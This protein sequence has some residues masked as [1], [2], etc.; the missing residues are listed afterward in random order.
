MTSRERRAGSGSG[1]LL[2]LDSLWHDAQGKV[3]D[4]RTL[5]AALEHPSESTTVAY[6]ALG[7]VLAAQVRNRTLQT[8][9]WKLEEF[10]PDA[11][12]NVWF[13]RSR[14]AADQT[15]VGSQAS[16]SGNGALTSQRAAPPTTCPGNPYYRDSLY[17]AVDLGGSV[18][19][20]GTLQRA[21]DATYTLQTASASYYAADGRLHV[22][23]RYQA[24]PGVGLGSWEEYWYDALGRRVL[25]RARRDAAQVC[26]IGV[27]CASF[28]QRTVW[29]GDQVLFEQRTS[30]LDAITG[31]APHWG[32]V[33]YVH[34]LGIDHPV[35]LL[36]GRVIHY[37]WRGL[38][39]ASSWADGTPADCQLMGGTCM[40]IAWPAG[41]GVYF[42]NPGTGAPGP[43][44]TWI[45]SL[46]ENGAGTTGQLYRRN[47]YYDPASG[48]FTQED[49]IGL[50]GGLNL[51]GFANGDPVTLSDPFGLCAVGGDYTYDQCGNQIGYT[52]TGGPD[53]HFMKLNSGATI[54]IDGRPI[55]EAT[56]YKIIGNAASLDRVAKM[57][58]D[59]EDDNYGIEDLN[60][61]SQ[62]GG[63]LDFKPD[64]YSQF[65]TRTLW[66]AGDVG[67]THMYV[68][69][70]KVANAAYARY[71]RRNTAAPEWL[72]LWGARR[73][74]RS[75]GA[76]GEPL[77]QLFIRRGWRIP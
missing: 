42:R 72:V 69:G 17:Q 47:R 25:V 26:N 44:P 31:G 2:Q 73:Q 36:D 7:A 60:S 13:Q 70:D 77:D 53:R 19:R 66:N 45:G 22:G 55:A 1:T 8:D 43:T 68:H 3:N 5:S 9:H 76:V 65:G 39:E 67:G 62:P 23:Q 33:G 46:P 34:I 11:F 56:P 10:R 15:H 21:C 37:N 6:A 38:G 50:A 71:V 27:A 18:I 57:I 24:T 51:Y 59:N 35:A 54:Q 14:R 41:Q 61:V 32:A 30:G 48:R 49:P 58:A 75:A 29:D 12:G 28:V 20:A 16:Y 63:D 52:E 4:V 74:A 40:T 64:V